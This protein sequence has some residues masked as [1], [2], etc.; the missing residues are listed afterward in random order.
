MSEH[1]G[2]QGAL[3]PTSDP[4]IDTA[5]GN[6]NGDYSGDGHTATAA[7]LYH[8]NAVATDAFGNVYIADTG[9]HRVRRVDAKTRTI[10]T[11]AGNGE[12]DF[13]G[14]D[15]PAIDAALSSPCGVA[16]DAEGNLY[17]ADTGNHRVRKVDAKTQA[18]TTYAGDDSAGFDGDEKAAD[19]ASLYTPFGVVV[20]SGGDLYIADTDNHRVRKVDAKTR[21]I[22]TVAGNG[23]Q[24]FSGDDEPAV[25]AALNRPRGVAVDPHGNLYIA[26]TDNDRVRRVDAKTRTITTVVGDGSAIFSN[27]FGAAVHAGLNRPR[28]VAVDSG[29]SLYVA[30]T[31][32]HRVRRVDAKTQTITTFAGDGSADYG[33]DGGPAAKASL[34][35][36]CGA[37]VSSDGSLYIADTRNNRVRKVS[38]LPVPAR[39]AVWSGGMTTLDRSG[40]A[41][42]PGVYVKA[43]G[44]GWIPPQT[45]S[46][47]LPKGKNLRFSGSGTLLV[48]LEDGNTYS[49]DGTLSEDQQTFTTN[50]PVDLHLS[51]AG[52]TNSLLIAVEAPD[53]AVL[54]EAQLTFTVGDQPPTASPVDVVVGFSVTP[55]GPTEL[56]RGQDLAMPGIYVKQL[57][58]GQVPPQ[59]VSVRL[60][61]GKNLQ[62]YGSGNLIVYVSPEEQY[63][64]GGRLSA[65]KQA[66][67]ADNVDLRLS[68]PGTS[69]S[70]LILVHTP[71]DAVLGEGDL[72]FTVGGK[73]A[74]APVDVI[75]E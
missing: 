19:E 32:N 37:A 43:L 59:T 8:P 38:S 64:Y 17:I 33:G 62:F 74:V 46:V 69:S 58:G 16:L 52:A 67:T 75:A 34:N 60:P 31:G 5:A 15:G 56:R 53:N 24:D 27:D 4:S 20:D 12:L 28:S 57:G 71:D 23:E 47:Q 68:G 63:P 66:F 35:G 1:G 30:D 70:L 51:G 10:S 11:V 42:W 41:G 14:D 21:T 61:E 18:I 40:G 39:I 50:S 9:N 54:G 26:D 22:T 65:D 3:E 45:V 55:G 29:G 72:T 2:T 73:Q 36:P 25:H 6:G 49:Y 44:G 48:Y 7:D 13:S